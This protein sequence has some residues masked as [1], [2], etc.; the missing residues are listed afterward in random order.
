ME[1]TL[2]KDGTDPLKVTATVTFDASDGGNQP[3]RVDWGDGTVTSVAKDAVSA[4]KT[5]AKAG[6]YHVV[7]QANDCRARDVITAGTLTPP[8][9]KLDVMAERTTTLADQTRGQFAVTGKLG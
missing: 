9:S 7:V 8:A 6:T 1:L 5:Y 2:T 3:Y 4:T